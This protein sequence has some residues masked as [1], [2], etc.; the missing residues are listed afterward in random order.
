MQWNSLFETFNAKLE[1]KD[2]SDEM[3]R[4]SSSLL[5]IQPESSNVWN[6]RKRMVLR[7]TEKTLLLNDELYLTIECL[8]LNPKSYA[9]WHHRYWTILQ[10]L[11]CDSAL[12][13][14]DIE[15]GLLSKLLDQDSRNCMSLLPVFLF[16]FLFLLCL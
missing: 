6:S 4:V 12:M 16:Q 2:D 5:K 9:T 8:K 13:S 10:L 11:Q 1:A 14:W 3:R 7:A 15:L